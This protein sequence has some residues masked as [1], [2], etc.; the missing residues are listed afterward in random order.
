MSLLSLEAEKTANII[1]IRFRSAFLSLII[2][3]HY[4]ASLPK[5]VILATNQENGGKDTTQEEDL[6]TA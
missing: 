5:K 2:Y 4:L 6:P 3:P 1:K